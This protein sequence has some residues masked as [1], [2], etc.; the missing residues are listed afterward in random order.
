MAFYL[1][2]IAFSTT[3]VELCL[4]RIMRRILSTA[5][6]EK[7]Q[8]PTAAMLYALCALCACVYPD[9]A[10]PFQCWLSDLSNPEQ[11]Q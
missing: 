10:W 3:S 11:T 5:G 6:S 4:A 7:A 9:M 2:A 1:P 8:V